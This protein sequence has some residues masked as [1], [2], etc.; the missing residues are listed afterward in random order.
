MNALTPAQAIP[1]VRLSGDHLA[2]TSLVI[3]QAFD[4]RHGDVLKAMRRL[5]CSEQFNRRNFAPI[6]YLDAR[7]RPQTMYEITRDGF[8]WLV[9][10]FSGA[11]AASWKEGFIAEFNRMEAELRAGDARQREKLAAELAR[12]QRQLITA[13]KAL[14]A[15][16]RRRLRDLLPARPAAAASSQMAL[17]LEGGAA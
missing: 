9:M 1:L 3:A 4:K 8:M 2:T 6:A 11:S 12:T 7:G 16:A 10:G 15:D 17:D 5:D 14:L 13:Q